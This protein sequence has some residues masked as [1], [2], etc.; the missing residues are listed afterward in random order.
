MVGSGQWAVGNGYRVR[1]QNSRSGPLASL[2]EGLRPSATSH[3]TLRHS[4]RATIPALPRWRKAGPEPDWASLGAVVVATTCACRGRAG[5]ALRAV[6]V[7]ALA[8]EGF[9]ARQ[10]LGTVAVGTEATRIRRMV[11]P[12][13]WAIGVFHLIAS[14]YQRV[15]ICRQPRNR[16]PEH[17]T[18]LPEGTLT[19]CTYRAIRHVG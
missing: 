11:A 3:G 16:Q 14:I 12:R 9:H 1:I 5:E 2:P 19:V 15:A 7:T 18:M 4:L 13:C 17:Q 6:V 10:Q 8:A